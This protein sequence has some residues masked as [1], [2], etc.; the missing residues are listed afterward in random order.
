MFCQFVHTFFLI[1][2]H[3]I[4]IQNMNLR[5]IVYHLI[6]YLDSQNQFQLVI[7]LPDVQLWTELNEPF[8]FPSRSNHNQQLNQLISGVLKHHSKLKLVVCV[9]LHLKQNLL[10]CL[11]H[12]TLTSYLYYFC[13]MH[14]CLSYRI[15]QLQKQE[16]KSII[17]Q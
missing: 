17:L 3:Q 11:L 14:C 9:N 8:H 7:Y 6:S 2:Y 13:K 4:Q 12:E 1:Q 16:Y 15:H 5:T 10:Y